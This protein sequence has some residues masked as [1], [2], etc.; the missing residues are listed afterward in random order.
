MKDSAKLTL[1][2]SKS[3]AQQAWAGHRYTWT[4][5]DVLKDFEKCSTGCVDMVAF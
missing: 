3:Y 4:S 2:E 1:E 5:E